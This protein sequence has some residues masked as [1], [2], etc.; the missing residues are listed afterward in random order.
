MADLVRER[1]GCWMPPARNGLEREELSS[2][3]KEALD[4]LAGCRP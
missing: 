2:G 3:I 4:S 1:D